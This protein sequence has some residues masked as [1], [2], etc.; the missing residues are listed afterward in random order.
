MSSL[1]SVIIT[2]SMTSRL[3]W[4]SAR[5]IR[6]VMATQSNESPKFR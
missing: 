1:T 2:Q 4:M 3:A 5:R 6:V